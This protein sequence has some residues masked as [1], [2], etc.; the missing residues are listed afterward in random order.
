MPDLANNRTMRLHALDAWVRQM[1]TIEARREAASNKPGSEQEAP[2]TPA[3][4]SSGGPIKR[5]LR[6]RG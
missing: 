1:E 3:D 2:P 6:R 5:M 4:E